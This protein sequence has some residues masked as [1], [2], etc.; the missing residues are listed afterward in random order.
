M[1]FALVAAAVASVAAAPT[2]TPKASCTLAAAG[3]ELIA[4]TDGSAGPVS[5]DLTG[6]TECDAVGCGDCEF[7]G[8]PLVGGFDLSGEPFDVNCCHFNATANACVWCLFDSDTGD[9]SPQ[10]FFTCYQ[11]AGN[12][13]TPAP[14]PDTER[15]TL[16]PVVGVTTPAP[17]L[18]PA[19]SPFP[20]PFITTDAPSSGNG[21]QAVAASVLVASTVALV[22]LL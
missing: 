5:F 1:R 11:D 13:I 7:A 18:T 8:N 20:N 3:L 16:S 9:C 21:A 22:F 19:P 14:N 15:P 10:D 6:S 12:A 17:V 4:P 2:Q